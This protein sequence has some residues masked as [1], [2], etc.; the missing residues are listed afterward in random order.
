MTEKRVCPY[1]EKLTNQELVT[2]NDEYNV[3]NEIITVENSFFVCSACEEEIEDNRLP[4]PLIDVYR[5]YRDIKGYIHPNELIGFRNKYNLT[6]KELS[7]MLGFGAVTLSRYENG[8][9]Q[10]DAHN[11]SLEM[12]MQPSSL[13]MLVEKNRST[14]AKEKYDGLLLALEKECDNLYC[15]S[16]NEIYRQLE[17]SK[18]DEFSGYSELNVLKLIEVIVFMCSFGGSLKTKLNKLLFYADFYGFKRQTKSIT[19]LR[20]IHLQYGPV[21]DNFDFVYAQLLKDGVLNKEEVS[22]SNGF[23]G[24]NFKAARETDWSL[25]NEDEREVMQLINR[26]FKDFS[27]SEIVD[28]SH[29]EK[30]YTDTSMRDVIS[31]NFSSKLAE[32]TPSSA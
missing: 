32:L 11:V 9:L 10:T 28:Y 25:F 18:I 15:G 26:I 19:G 31:Y 3:R 30:A 5:K 12:A 6:Q 24:E 7:N 27:S 8:A 21:P 29:K 22:F 16:S 14:F 4:D 13:K 20:Y 1:C 23:V 2:K 17:H